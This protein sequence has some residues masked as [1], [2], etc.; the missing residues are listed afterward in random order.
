MARRLILAVTVAAA[1][2]AAG[3]ITLTRVRRPSGIA[4]LVKASVNA[5]SRPVEARLSGGFPYRPYAGPQRGDEAQ[6]AQ[7][8]LR[9][10]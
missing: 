10:G 8:Y 4:A 2:I 5:P 3:A 6:A 7:W 9:G 1:V